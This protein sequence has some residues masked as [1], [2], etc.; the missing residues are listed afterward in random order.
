MASWHSSVVA[1]CASWLFTLFSF[2]Y[3]SMFCYSRRVTSIAQ[4]PRIHHLQTPLLITSVRTLS[5]LVHSALL[6]SSLARL[7]SPP[8]PHHPQTNPSP[9]PFFHHLH[10]PIPS[11]PPR[12][13]PS[14]DKKAPSSITH[15]A[16]ATDSHHYSLSS[17]LQ[18]RFISLVLSPFPVCLTSSTV[19]PP[20]FC[21]FSFLRSLLIVCAKP[22][23][24]PCL[25]FPQPL[26]LN[27]TLNY[28]PST[29]NQPSTISHTQTPCPSHPCNT[30]AT[31][32]RWP[33]SFLSCDCSSSCVV[34]V[35]G[36]GLVDQSNKGDRRRHSQ[37]SPG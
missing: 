15:T 24:L 31:Q 22:P 16:R 27:P 6:I 3:L 34:G 25:R 1:L 18:L 2:A 14:K 19:P 21:Q 26:C 7:L 11:S 35:G 9:S 28:P 13:Q 17:P 23:L 4:L 29:F 36:V 8:S 33:R 10:T 5:R 32:Q 37:R 20:H 30:S 12:T